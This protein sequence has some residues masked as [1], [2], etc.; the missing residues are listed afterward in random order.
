MNKIDKK[1]MIL[2]VIFILCCS[3][4]FLLIEN[5]KKE[6]QIKNVSQYLVL[7]EN[8][9]WKY[10][11]GNWENLNISSTYDEINWKKFNIYTNNSY[12]NTYKYVYMD[13]ESY[14]FD[15]DNNDY[16]I[17]DNNLLI[18][19]GTYFK[20]KKFQTVD[21]NIK[22]NEIVSNFLEKYNKEFEELTIKKKYEVS[23]NYSIYIVSNY[24]EDY[25][26]EDAFY[27][28]FARINFKNYLLV[29]SNYFINNITYDLAY[30]LDIDNKY[31][32]IIL[33]FNCDESICYNM[34]QYNDGKYEEVI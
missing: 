28:V 19:N 12:Y 9:F 18:N 11:K 29:N 10:S 26:K 15:D 4:L 3:V 34:F 25:D 23:N 21:F 30:V 16:T 7:D 5:D 2:L 20:I 14:F 1:F 8:Y 31:Y 24:V 27:L 6:K 17:P 32:N 22:D 33:N 13:N